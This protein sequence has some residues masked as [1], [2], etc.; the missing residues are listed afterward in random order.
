MAHPQLKADCA[1]C[2]ALCC[3]ALSFDRS[4]HFAIDKAAGQPCPN[5]DDCHS[6]GI[7]QHLSARGFSGCVRYDCAGAGQRVT[8]E[9]FEGRT[10]RDDQALLRPMMDAFRAMREVHDLMSMLLVVVKMD[11]SDDAR[12]VCQAFLDDL[13][14][15]E[16]WTVESL[17]AF[18]CSAIPREVRLF[19]RE[20]R[21]MVSL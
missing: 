13:S 20:L 11:I 5:L 6:C 1:Q 10:W 2:A 19:L 3:V 12:V 7:H 18:E 15:V 4:E 14:P 9:V 8:Q 21:G 17:F 16:P